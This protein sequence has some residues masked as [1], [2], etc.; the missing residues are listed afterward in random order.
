MLVTSLSTKTVSVEMEV[1]IAI[2]LIL[3]NKV[4]LVEA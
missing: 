3:F 4:I 1:S 2:N